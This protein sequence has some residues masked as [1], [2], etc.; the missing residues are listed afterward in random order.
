MLTK[1][2]F[3]L[4][5][6]IS[7]NKR[8]EFNLYILKNRSGT[9]KCLKLTIWHLHKLVDYKGHEDEWGTNNWKHYELFRWGKTKARGDK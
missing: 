5:I 8:I 6:P 2:L 3:D 1:N 7:K 4:Y 9:I